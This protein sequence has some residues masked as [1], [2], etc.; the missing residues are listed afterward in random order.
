MTTTTPEHAIE[1]RS[2][3]SFNEYRPTSFR[4]RK[5]ASPAR[6]CP[7]AEQVLASIGSLLDASILTHV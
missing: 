7:G 4:L 2:N 1:A 6:T 5:S 3:C